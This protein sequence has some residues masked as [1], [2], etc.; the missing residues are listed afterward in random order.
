MNLGVQLVRDAFQNKFEHAAVI[1]NDTDLVEAIC[2][3]TQEVKLPVTL[4]CPG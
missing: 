2:I 3:V 4:I 1:T